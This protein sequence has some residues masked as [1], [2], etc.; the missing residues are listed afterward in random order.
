MLELSLF[1]QIPSS[2]HQQVLQILAG[3]AAMPPNPT[4][5][6]HIV[7]RPI[8]QP[9]RVAAQVGGS[10]G[11]Q[12]AQKAARQ[13]QAQGQGD[14]YYLR[15]VEDLTMAEMDDNAT[16]ADVAAKLRWTLHFYDVPDAGRKELKVMTRSCS[17][18]PVLEGDV[19][20]FMQGLGY[21]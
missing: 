15:L 8:K 19:I 1:S 2:R 20:G 6:R 7:F 13:A 21:Q 14:M 11:I 3:I 12:D 10:Q 9:I 17:M 16:D 4:L 5:E 18:T